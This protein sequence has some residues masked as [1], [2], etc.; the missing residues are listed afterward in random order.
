VFA[1]ATWFGDNLY[2]DNIY[3]TDP[4][5]GNVRELT[6]GGGRGIQGDLE[7]SISPDGQTVVFTRD[8][9]RGNPPVGRRVDLYTV[10]I[11]GGA[12]TRITDTP[13]FDESE[14]VWS[15]D[16]TKIAFTG[17]EQG[18]AS[19]RFHVYPI[20]ADGTGLQQLTSG[21]AND[22]QPDWQPIAGPQ[23][24]NYENAAQFCKAERDFL[25]DAAFAKKHG[26]NANGTNAYGKCVSQSP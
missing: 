2:A 11:A 1:R 9:P 23:R 22:G 26:T 18:D 14:P 25:G 16:G 21:P 17:K 19:A 4:S 7:P 10:P 5:G 6:S 12:P 24:S 20:N 3:V 8:L 13:T 15:P